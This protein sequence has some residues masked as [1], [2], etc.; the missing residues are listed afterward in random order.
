MKPRGTLLIYRR[1]PSL[2]DMIKLRMY[3]MGLAQTKL[4]ELLNFTF[5]TDCFNSVQIVLFHIAECALFILTIL[6][7]GMLHSFLVGYPRAII[8]SRL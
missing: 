6:C 4:S 8:M 7:G 5:V 2:V 1:L 3:E